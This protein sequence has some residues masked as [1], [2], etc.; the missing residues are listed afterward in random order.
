MFRSSSDYLLQWRYRNKI[1]LLCKNNGRERINR[2]SVTLFGSITMSK[3]DQYHI[4]ST[5]SNLIGLTCN[6]RAS[7]VM[8]ENL[9]LLGIW[10]AI[11]EVS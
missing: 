11:G 5:I 8:S 10:N 9:T 2:D 6:Y 3:I 1:Y 7:R 4:H